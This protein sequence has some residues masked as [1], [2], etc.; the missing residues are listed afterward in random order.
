M[1]PIRTVVFW[2]KWMLVAAAA[3]ILLAHLLAYTLI[4]W[5]LY[6]YLGRP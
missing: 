1:T 6:A 2:L 4:V 5:L 3:G